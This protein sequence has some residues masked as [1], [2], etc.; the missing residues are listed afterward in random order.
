MLADHVAEQIDFANLAQAAANPVYKCGF[1]RV[2]D[3]RRMN[4][5]GRIQR[6][7]SLAAAVLARSTT[8]LYFL[9]LHDTW[10]PMTTTIKPQTKRHSCCSEVIDTS[11]YISRSSPGSSR[12]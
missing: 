8:C 4:W 12:A 2:V 5:G 6:Q 1:S 10:K 3:T 11:T 9:K 7:M